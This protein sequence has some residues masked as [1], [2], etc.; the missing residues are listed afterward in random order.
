MHDGWATRGVYP[1]FLLE[2]ATRGGNPSFI[3]MEDSRLVINHSFLL[4]VHHSDGKQSSRWG[5]KFSTPKFYVR[6][7][8]N[9][10]QVFLTRR[11]DVY[12]DF[13]FLHLQHYFHQP[14]GYGKA[15]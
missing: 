11:L 7:M 5:S 8:E 4:P 13:L 15:K 6:L 1:V 14:N 9:S 2:W 10:L 3:Q 12:K